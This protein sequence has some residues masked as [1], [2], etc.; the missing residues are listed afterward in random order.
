MVDS[1]LLKEMNLSPSLILRLGY[2]LIYLFKL[3]ISEL[4]EHVKFKYLK[5]KLMVLFWWFR[6]QFKFGKNIFQLLSDKSRV[7]ISL[8][9]WHIF[10]IKIIACK[11]LSLTFK[12]Q[13]KMC[14]FIF[15]YAFAQS[16]YT[17][18]QVISWNLFFTLLSLPNFFQLDHL[19]TKNTI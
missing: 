3:K 1:F 12:S 8:F 4:F 11:K 2:F 10:F 15:H 19:I 6:I 18:I 5:M 17:F 7:E 14:F 9:K 16:Y 13:S